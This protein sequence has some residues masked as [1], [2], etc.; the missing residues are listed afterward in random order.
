MACCLIIASILLFSNVHK[1]FSRKGYI[2]GHKTSLNKLKNTEII[3]TIFSD[4]DI[5]LTVTK[6]RKKAKPT[7]M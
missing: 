1:L 3:S 5:K 4:H 7:T 6:K 2:L